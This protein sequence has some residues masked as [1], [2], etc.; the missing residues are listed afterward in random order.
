M[1]SG[2]TEDPYPRQQSH[3][4]LLSY[5]DFDR[6]EPHT[7]KGLTILRRKVGYAFFGPPTKWPDLR[8]GYTGY[9]GNRLETVKAVA[10]CLIELNGKKTSG[11]RDQ[12]DMAFV[13]VFVDYRDE[14]LQFPVFRVRMS[15]SECNFVDANCRV[16]S[17]WNNFLETN[18]LPPGRCCWPLNGVYCGDAQGNVQVE[19][20]VTPGT[21]NEIQLTYN[22]LNVTATGV[23]FGFRSVPGV[24]PFAS[25]V[26]FFMH[27]SINFR[28]AVSIMQEVRQGVLQ[29][30]QEALRSNENRKEF[31]KLVRDAVA[32]SESVV[33]ERSNVIRNVRNVENKEDFFAGMV[34]TRRDLRDYT[35]IFLENGNIIVNERAEIDSVESY[36]LRGQQ[37][38]ELLTM[39]R[40]AVQGT[41]SEVTL[42]SRLQK[43]ARTGSWVSSGSPAFEASDRSTVAVTALTGQLQQFF[44]EIRVGNIEVMLVVMVVDEL[45]IRIYDDSR[46]NFVRLWKLIWKHV[47]NL[48]GQ[49]IKAYEE[50]KRI[51][52]KVGDFLDDRNFNRQQGINM[53]NI[54]VHYVI[55][56]FK[57]YSDHINDLIRDVT[58]RE[59]SDD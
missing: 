51:A 20:G 14:V 18:E 3:Y 35:V 12:L 11:N 41:I 30:Y 47:I 6:Y 43:A 26:L 37:S 27:A 42:I 55:N 59:S 58:N 34:R 8:N 53:T 28:T 38:Q 32:A 1:A 13:F 23:R 2:W 29:D 39:A 9:S 56:V 5:T 33:N 48:T 15:E 46:R 54:F 4:E 57:R 19:W 7:E 45:T 21:T 50:R 22:G 44:P 25:S 10:S 36:N 40:Q 17:T 16:Y 52:Q 31:R 49:K 24:F